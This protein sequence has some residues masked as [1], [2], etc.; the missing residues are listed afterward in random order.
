MAQEPVVT[1]TVTVVL[2]WAVATVKDSLPTNANLRVCEM[3]QSQKLTTQ[4]GGGFAL[5]AQ[6]C[7]L[8][9]DMHVL[10]AWSC[11]SHSEWEKKV[12]NCTN[13]THTTLQQ[14]C[15]NDIEP[16][17]EGIMCTAQQEG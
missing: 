3:Q 6:V 4:M 16:V 10:R 15:C 1:A 13:Q 7:L 2:P 11:H 8:N 14:Q 17:P 9:A 5:C 12:S